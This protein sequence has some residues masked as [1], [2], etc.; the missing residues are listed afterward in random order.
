MVHS[1]LNFFHLKGS[2]VSIPK[3]K[4]DIYPD[5]IIKFPTIQRYME[6]LEK[7]EEKEL[8]KK[9]INNNFKSTYRVYLAGPITGL[10]YKGAVDWRQE[11]KK[12]LLPIIGISPMRAKE[13]FKDVTEFSATCVGYE[14]YSCLS[15]ARGIM[16]RDHWD[17]T[18]CDIVLVNFLGA[19]KVSIGTVMEIAWAWDHNIPVIAIMEQEGNPHEHGMITEAVGFRVETLDNAIEVIKGICQE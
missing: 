12:K 4:D 8:Q 14:Q 5:K 11:A 16:T 19:Q 18:R 3:Y 6:V 1:I 13:Y 2:N 15:S 10:D 9:T 17:A 7:E